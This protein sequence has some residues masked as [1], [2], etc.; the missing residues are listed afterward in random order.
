MHSVDS[1]LE[2]KY[3]PA[4]LDYSDIVCMYKYMTEWPGYKREMDRLGII[5]L[6]GVFN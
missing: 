2:C 4:V 3:A 6:K 1:H 5:S